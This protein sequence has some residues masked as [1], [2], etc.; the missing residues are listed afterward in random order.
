MLFSLDESSLFQ[1][2]I[3]DKLAGNLAFIVGTD[4]QSRLQIIKDV[5]KFYALRS[6]LVHGATP[7]LNSSYMIFNV[8]LRASINELLNNKKYE[9]VNDIPV[10]YEMLREAQNSY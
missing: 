9:K 7:E 1:S 4:K 3:A 6:G 5:K 8:L 10:L 2:S